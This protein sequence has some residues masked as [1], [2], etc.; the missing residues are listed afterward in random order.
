MSRNPRQNKIPNNNTKMLYISPGVKSN[1]I[2]K[3]INKNK[4]FPD[5]AVKAIMYDSFRY[6]NF[7]LHFIIFLFIIAPF[8]ITYNY[9]PCLFISYQ[10]HLQSAPQSFYLML[11]YPLCLPPQSDYLRRYLLKIRS[12][13]N[14]LMH[15]SS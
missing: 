5:P 11:V 9:Y 12:L 6:L 4:M 7:F 13:Y 2:Y 15:I 8:I 3:P 10:T 14:P 1:T